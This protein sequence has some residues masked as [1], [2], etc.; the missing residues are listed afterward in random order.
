[1]STKYRAGSLP[2]LARLQ[3][4]V[5]SREQV[6][7]AGIARTT[8]DARVSSG[9]WERLYAG[10][11]RIEGTPATWRQSLL[12]A[13]LAWSDGRP[14]ERVGDASLATGAQGRP[15]RAGCA[16]SSGP[17]PRR[18]RLPRRARRDRSRRVRV[19]LEPQA[20]RP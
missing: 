3:H 20:A 14:G 5:F 2:A 15:P 11:Y 17:L 7:A 8:I 12:A 9:T 18:L 1:M 19:A 6:L 4:G 16:V 13:C 10:V